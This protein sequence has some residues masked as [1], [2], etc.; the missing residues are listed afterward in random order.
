MKFYLNYRESLENPN[1]LGCLEFVLMYFKVHKYS[2]QRSL[3]LSKELPLSFNTK[4][5]NSNNANTESNASK[6]KV[7]QIL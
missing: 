1:T 5:T 2:W 4:A 7:E 6:I 3:T